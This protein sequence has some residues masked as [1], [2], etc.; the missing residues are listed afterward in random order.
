VAARH[1]QRHPPR[2]DAL[3]LVCAVVA[4]SSSRRTTHRGQNEPKRQ[5]PRPG[6]I[7]DRFVTRY[8]K[9]YC[10]A[11]DRTYDTKAFASLALERLDTAA[12]GRTGPAQQN[13]VPRTLGGLGKSGGGP[14]E[15]RVSRANWD[16]DR[17]GEASE[18]A[19]VSWTDC[20]H[21]RTAPCHGTY[22]IWSTAR[23]HPG[24]CE[25]RKGR[26]P[27]PAGGGGPRL[28]QERGFRGA[29]LD[30]WTARPAPGSGS[31]RSDLLRTI[32]HA[33]PAELASCCGGGGGGCCCC[34][35]RSTGRGEGRRGVG[36]G[37][38]ALL[39]SPHF[40]RRGQL[41]GSGTGPRRRIG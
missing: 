33:D 1:Y 26:G 41:R 7:H 25:R 6:G 3:H 15:C 28:V 21:V 29:L 2:R 4:A 12:S 11:S 35:R 23:T 34:P 27:W 36:E 22:P 13:A 40:C 16:A 24:P 39:S 19:A 32:V 5:H 37:V 10:G 18:R 30:V 8:L 14:A 9:Q 20:V 17:F 31:V 38:P